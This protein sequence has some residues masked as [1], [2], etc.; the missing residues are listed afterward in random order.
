M[1]WG[2]GQPV[3]GLWAKVKRLAVTDVG[4]LMRGLGKDEL[5]AFERTLIEADLGVAAA[6]ELVA[7]VQ[8]RVR[9]G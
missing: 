4:A 8:E 2:D 9:R 7:E 1:R 6:G 5:R 3:S